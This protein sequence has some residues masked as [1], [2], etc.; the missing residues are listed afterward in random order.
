MT[1]N[2]ANNGQSGPLIPHAVVSAMVDGVTP[3]R[4]WREYLG[5][6]PEDLAKRMG[7]SPAALALLEDTPE[8]SAMTREQIAAALGIAPEQL[9][10]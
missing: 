1:S 4:A 8:V 7:I 9:D 10:V 5:L 6:T 2:T 3:I